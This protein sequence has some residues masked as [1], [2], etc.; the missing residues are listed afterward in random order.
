MHYRD[1]SISLAYFYVQHKIKYHNS[2]K[3]RTPPSV[4]TGSVLTFDNLC[5][6]KQEVYGAELQLQVSCTGDIRASR[7]AK[8]GRCSKN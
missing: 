5:T 6:T 7:G 8:D 2:K 1:F 4:G 3:K